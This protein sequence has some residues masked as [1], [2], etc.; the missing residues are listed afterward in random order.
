MRKYLS[1][2]PIAFLICSALYFQYAIRQINNLLLQEKLIETVYTVD[3]LAAAAEANHAL[4]WDAHEANI[5]EAVTSLDSLHQ[6]F[7]GAYKIDDAGHLMLFSKRNYE[8]SIFD[9]TSYSEFISAVSN[10]HSGNIVIGHTPV[11]QAYRD[12]YIYF[13]WMPLYSPSDKRFLVAAGVSQYS[14]VTQIPVLISVGLWVNTF[15]TFLFNIWL[16]FLILRPSKR[17]VDRL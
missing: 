13:R 15:V 14:V 4:A 9:P 5:R 7:A 17:G 16:V 10:S 12:L 8:T 1:L 3:I 6:I 11:G 2:I